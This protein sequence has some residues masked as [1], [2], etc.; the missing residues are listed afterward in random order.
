MSTLIT[1][2]VQGVTTIKK[3]AS[4]TNATL[5]A[6][7]TITPGNTPKLS[8][9]W[10][11]S[12]KIGKMNNDYATFASS[13][14]ASDATYMQTSLY[15]I[16]PRTVMIGWYF[17][18]N[19]FVSGFTGGYGWGVQLPSNIIPVGGPGF[20]YQAIPSNYFSFN[21]TNHFN[22]TPHRWQANT[23][24]SGNNHNILSLY[25]AQNNTNWASGTFE[26]SAT[27]I[28]VLASDVTTAYA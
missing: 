8:T 7:G 19:S 1:T 26:S 20:C 10:N 27:G 28:F 18:K 25:G 5:N 16:N 2:T 21:G 14:S 3:D 23:N 24:N 9:E 17:Y 11:S 15:L 4:T 12:F 22:A 13:M 6:N